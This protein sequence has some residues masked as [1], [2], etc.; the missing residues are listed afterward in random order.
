MKSRNYEGC[1]LNGRE[2]KADAKS[3]HVPETTIRDVIYHS[4]DKEVLWDNSAS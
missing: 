1:L 3:P 2:I 4:H